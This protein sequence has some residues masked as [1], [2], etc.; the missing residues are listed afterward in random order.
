MSLMNIVFEKLGNEFSTLKIKKKITNKIIIKK[1]N[2]Y[3]INLTFNGDTIFLYTVLNWGVLTY[4]IDR[5]TD[6]DVKLLKSEIVT[7]LQKNNFD[8]SVIQ[9]KW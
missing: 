6:D 1:N 4:L 5:K 2:S 3:S 8:Y 7:F 9:K